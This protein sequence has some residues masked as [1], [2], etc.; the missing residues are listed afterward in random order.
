MT[1]HDSRVSKKLF[2]KNESFQAAHH[3]APICPHPVNKK[4]PYFYKVLFGVVFNGLNAWLC[5]HVK[6][7][8]VREF[9][10]VRFST[11]NKSSILAG[12]AVRSY[13][14]DFNKPC[15]TASNSEENCVGFL[16]RR[17]RQ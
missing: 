10:R 11:Q 4:Y 1:N 17:L 2:K 16:G 5:F 15:Y 12:P 9:E 8:S 14:L 6:G 7:E 13:L 3:W